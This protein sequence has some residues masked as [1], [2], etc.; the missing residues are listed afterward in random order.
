MIG[1]P[2]SVE[3]DGVS[4]TGSL[5]VFSLINKMAAKHGVGRLDMV[6]NRFLGLKVINRNTYCN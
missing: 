3:V 4:T 6:E 2:T 1:T 5:E